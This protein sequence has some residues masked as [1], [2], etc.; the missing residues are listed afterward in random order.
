MEI[1]F[2]V[3]IR[4]RVNKPK[5][6]IVSISE[7]IYLVDVKEK[8]ENNKANIEIVKYFSKLVGK[9]VRIVSGL[10]SKKKKIDVL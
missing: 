6:Q 8:A 9:R 5:T 4:V 7:G 3:Y 1:E 10:K 2:P